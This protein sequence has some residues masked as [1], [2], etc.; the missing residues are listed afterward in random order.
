MRVRWVCPSIRPGATRSPPSSIPSV[1]GPAR[2]ATS[3]SG[4]TKAI[5]SPATARPQPSW[6][7]SV[8]T[9]S[10]APPVRTRSAGSLPWA[11]PASRRRVAGAGCSRTVIAPSVAQGGEHDLAVEDGELRLRQD[12]LCLLGRAGDAPLV[13]TRLPGQGGPLRI[14]PPDDGG[15]RRLGRGPLEEARGAGLDGSRDTRGLRR[16]G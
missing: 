13:G 4:P 9:F 3:A 16:R 6:T 8:N 11:T 10:K 1:S 12:G 2:A 14:R 5:L 7:S 15:P